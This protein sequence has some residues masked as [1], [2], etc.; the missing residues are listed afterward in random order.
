MKPFWIKGT[1]FQLI[2]YCKPKVLILITIN[3]LRSNY[4]TCLSVSK[5]NV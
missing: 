5:Q 1:T 4:K 3:M 2:V